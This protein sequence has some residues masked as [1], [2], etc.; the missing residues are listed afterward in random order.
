M[1]QCSS[2]HSSSCSCSRT[3]PL[4]M[5]FGIILMAVVLAVAVIVMMLLAPGMLINLIFDRF[6]EHPDGFVMASMQD[7][8]T[9]VASLSFWGAVY[10]KGKERVD[11]FVVHV[12]RLQQQ[13]PR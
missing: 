6:A 9:W 5:V 8:F 4:E 2:C 10:I 7:Y 3:S 1:A 11:R 12:Q 13:L